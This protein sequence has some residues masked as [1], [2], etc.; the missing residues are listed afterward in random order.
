MVE[1]LFN[2]K[3][4]KKILFYSSVKTKK[5]FSIQ[6]FYRTDIYILRELGYTVILSKS[7]FNYFLFWKYDIAFI[8]FYRYGL[9]PALI[10]KLFSKKVIFTGGIDYLDRKYAGIKSYIIQKIFINLC[11]LFSDK[12]ILV[13]NSDLVNVRK[14]IK[15]FNPSNFPLSFHVINCED[16]VY[17][18]ITNKKKIFCTIAWMLQTENVI[19]K[20]VD[21]SILLFKEIYLIDPDFRMIIIGPK[22]EGTAY[23]YEIIKKEK[24]EEVVSFT[25]AIDEKSKIKILQE[26]SIYSQLS[27]YE[28][29]GIASIEALAAGNIVIHTGKGGLADAIGVNGILT[30]GESY[31]IIAKKLFNIL[32]NNELRLKMVRQGIDHVSKNFSYAKR[33]NDFENIFKSI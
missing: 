18:I 28:G 2:H 23:I 7:I 30:S 31:Q 15:S 25:G 13:S 8:Y 4:R 22:G 17:D 11:N 32:Y 5:M 9:F 20:G 3:R 16:F 27:I 19:R 6:Q 1:K 29:F 12:N 24:L 21:K 26:S 33:Y 14:A 10:A